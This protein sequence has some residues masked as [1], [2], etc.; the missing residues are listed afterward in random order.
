MEEQRRRGR[1]VG[2]FIEKGSSVTGGGRKS[3]EFNVAVGDERSG[4]G[5]RE[6]P[7]GPG[8]NFYLFTR[9]VPVNF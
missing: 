1:E 5:R 7:R 9:T 3:G 2:G 8:E 6:G 4:R